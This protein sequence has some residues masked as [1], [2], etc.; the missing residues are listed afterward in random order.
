MAAF[1]SALVGHVIR[2]FNRLLLD[3]IVASSCRTGKSILS[4]TK[5]SRSF[6][7][8]IL[9]RIHDFQYLFAAVIPLHAKCE[10][11][12]RVSEHYQLAPTRLDCGFC[13]IFCE[14]R[15]SAID[16]NLG[17]SPAASEKALMI[18][19]ILLAFVGGAIGSVWR[20][21]LSGWV[22]QR[23]GET[24]PVGTLVVN[25]T[26]SLLIGFVANY[27]RSDLHRE[28][29]DIVRVFVA[30]GICGGLTTFSS[31]ILQTFHL[32]REKRFWIALANTLLSTVLCIGMVVAG[33]WLATLV[34][35]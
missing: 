5:R 26:G 17:S 32:L 2:K 22:A 15:S 14:Q 3:W 20:Y 30:V 33:W 16:R 10:L 18:G 24:L 28:F 25:L 1:A 31:F 11:E 34:L 29:A 13:R 23:I 12:R 35:G 4:R 7:D 9:W 27:A 21:S 8:W 6:N 19:V